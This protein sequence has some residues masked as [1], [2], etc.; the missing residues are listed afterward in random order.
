MSQSSPSR[1]K[2]LLQEPFSWLYS[3][4]KFSRPHT[5]IGTSLSIFALY[6]ITFD[7]RITPANFGQLMGS[8]LACLCGNIYIVGLNQ[9]EDVA[10]DQINKPHL[11]IAA[12]EF[13]PQQ[14]K[15]IVGIT[16]ILALLIAGGQGTWLLATVGISLVIGTAYSLPPMR[17]K[18]FPFWAAICIFTVRGVVVNLGIFLHFSQQNFIP[19]EV[20]ALTLFIVVFT[21]AIAIFKDVP[22]MEGDKQYQI[23]TF[24]LL[25]G[26]QAV[27]NLTLSVITFCYLAM[28]FAGIFW[29]PKVNSVFLVIAHLILL[30]LLWWRSR[31]VNLGAKQEIANFYQ[32]IWKLFF[33][34]YLL[35]PAAFLL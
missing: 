22:D 34:E 6:L 13:S 35:F 29:L 33:L 5:I 8:W 31:S 30:G 7:S 19:P 32:F 3:F 12:G 27:F 25:L 26:N 11:P 28:I 24:T 17:L 2:N 18:R 9:L 1:P 16:G 4:W 15:W 10:I 20:W 23:T 14:G 21:V